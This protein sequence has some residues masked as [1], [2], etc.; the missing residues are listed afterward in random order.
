[1]QMYSNPIWKKVDKSKW[2]TLNGK[3]LADS[4]ARPREIAFNKTIFSQAT[5]MDA[6]NTNPYAG[7]HAAVAMEFSGRKRCPLKE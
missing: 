7:G 5:A 6:E 1:M 4:S 3:N 2:R